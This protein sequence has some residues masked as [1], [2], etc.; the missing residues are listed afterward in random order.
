MKGML[1]LAKQ[2]RYNCWLSVAHMQSIKE[3]TAP[4]YFTA[5]KMASC[6]GCLSP[7]LEDV[8]WVDFFPSSF[9]L[10]YSLVLP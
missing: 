5:P 2:V 4:F 6:F 10:T 3:I 9:E 8:A 7:P 1:T